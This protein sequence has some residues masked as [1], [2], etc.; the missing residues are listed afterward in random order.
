MC[1]CLGDGYSWYQLA[2]ERTQGG[3][4][5][6]EGE[7]GGGGWGGGGG[8]VGGGGVYRKRG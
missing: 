3:K 1:L 8:G 4:G 5:E 6:G 7:E 2:M